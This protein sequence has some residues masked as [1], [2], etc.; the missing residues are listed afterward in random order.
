ME[1]RDDGQIKLEYDIHA[2]YQDAKACHFHDFHV[3]GLDLPKMALVQRLEKLINN[4]KDGRYD[5]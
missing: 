5:N 4:V 3:N 2:L 1:E